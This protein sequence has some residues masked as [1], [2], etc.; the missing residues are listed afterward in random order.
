MRINGDDFEKIVDIFCAVDRIQFDT[1]CKARR[2][3]GAYRA[4]DIYVFSIVAPVTG[5]EAE[6]EPATGIVKLT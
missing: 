4:R 3:D 1:C 6:I 5:S 2:D